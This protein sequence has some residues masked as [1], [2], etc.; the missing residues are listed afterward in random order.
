[1][2]TAIIADD[3]KDLVEVFSDLLS[4]CGVNVVATAFNG[5]D[6]LEK[7]QKHNPDVI[8]IDVAM[9]GYDGFYALEHIKIEHPESNIIMLTGD[10]SM[11]TKE[12]LE[13]MNATQILNKPIN[14][15]ILLSLFN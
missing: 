1:M 5:K 4:L 6:A 9:P 14:K 11:K 3:E 7:Y 13:T 10:P 8:L 12:K 2:K 15:E